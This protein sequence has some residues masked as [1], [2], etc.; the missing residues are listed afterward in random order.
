[1]HPFPSKETLSF[2]VG[3]EL[4]NV[5]LQPY[6]LDFQFTDGTWLMAEYRVEYANRDEITVHNIQDD[7]GPIT[8]HPLI[9]GQERVLAIDVSGDRLSLIF[10]GGRKMTVVSNFGPYESG[11][12]TRNDQLIV[13]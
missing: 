7:L 6:S 1:M 13:F 2:L 12:I 10:A 9:R 11:H 8:F 4:S 3:L 5:V